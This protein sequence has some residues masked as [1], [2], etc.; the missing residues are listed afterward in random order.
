MK[1]HQP[2]QEIVHTRNCQTVADANANI[3]ANADAHANG[4]RTKTCPPPS[5]I[6]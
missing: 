6:Q 5:D 3:N 2:V 1:I 4:T